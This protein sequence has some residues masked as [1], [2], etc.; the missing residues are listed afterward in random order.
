MALSHGLFLG[1]RQLTILTPSTISPFFRARLFLPIHRLTSRLM[2]QLALSQINTNT[3]LLMAASFWQHHSKKRVVIPL[4]GRPSTKRNHASL[5]SVMYSPQ[6]EMAFGSGSSFSTD[7]STRRSG[8]PASPKLCKFGC[9]TLLH[10][11]SSSKPTTQSTLSSARCISRSRRLF[12][13]R[14]GGRER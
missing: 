1:N 10:Q 6:Q 7:C 3:F 4:T 12:F 14:R 5:S 11:H 9:L 13:F 8:S 2:C